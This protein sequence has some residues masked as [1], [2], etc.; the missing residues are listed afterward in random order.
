MALAM[1]CPF[2]WEARATD[3]IMAPRAAVIFRFIRTSLEIGDC[4]LIF[5]EEYVTRSL[6]GKALTCKASEEE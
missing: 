1:T 3:R 6:P 4:L 2:A 5:S